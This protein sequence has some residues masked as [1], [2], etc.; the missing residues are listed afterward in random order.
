MTRLTALL[1]CVLCLLLRSLAQ[2]QCS[3]KSD[4]NTYLDCKIAERRAANEQALKGT[5]AI[6]V[7]AARETN[8]EEAASVAPQSTSL[9]DQ[10]SASDLFNLALNLAKLSSGM[11][12]N[13]TN[14]VTV[15]TSLYSLYSAANFH[16]PLDPAFYFRNREWRRVY[17]TLGRDVPDASTTSTAA[18]SNA[19]GE[20]DPAHRKQPGTIGGIKFV[21]WDRRDI[22]S[23]SNDTEFDAVTSALKAA[24]VDRAA[25]HLQLVNAIPSFDTQYTNL[26][27]EQESLMNSLVDS[28]LATFVKLDEVAT[29]AAESIR[30]NSQWS[31]S[32]T[33]DARNS[34]G[35]DEH[36][37]EMLF[38]RGLRSRLNLTANGGFDFIN[39]KKFGENLEGGR[40][41]ADLQFRITE[42]LSQPQPFMFH[43]SCET[44]GF[45]HATPIYK[46][47][48]KLVIPLGQKTGIEVP[49][50][51]TY[52]SRPDLIQESRLQGRFGF[53][54]DAQKIAAA[55]LG[56]NLR[57]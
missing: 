14:S 26:S 35:Y 1:M 46:G 10:S 12:P 5:V 20:L 38:D 40:F 23:P 39:A 45:T 43:I 3:A 42:D 32:Y 53:T 33:V 7:N 49:L 18:S 47:Q 30:N 48:I 16:D 52:A 57:N 9:V 17:L 15:T 24:S 44:R 22:T 41:A 2:G 28:R 50:S 54:F 27:P 34:Q 19:N 56:S 31:V 36:R 55:L 29:K 21:L 6:K 25:L 11:G 51:V 37:A 8:Q 4:V 13:D